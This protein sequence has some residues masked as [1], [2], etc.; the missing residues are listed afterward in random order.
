MVVSE[1][2]EELEER[3]FL[4]EGIIDVHGKQ[5]NNEDLELSDSSDDADNMD[6][7]SKE[8]EDNEAKK[9]E[10]EEEAEHTKIESQ[11]E[12]MKVKEVENAKPPQMIGVQLLKDSD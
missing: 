2:K 7:N 9:E 10:T 5:T 3:C 12:R 11:G 4:G 6:D 1:L 8:E